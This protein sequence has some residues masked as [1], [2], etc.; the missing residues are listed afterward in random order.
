MK[1]YDERREGSSKFN[2][3]VESEGDKMILIEEEPS[4][5]LEMWQS[6]YDGLSQNQ[7]ATKTKTGVAGDDKNN[8]N[9]RKNCTVGHDDESST[10]PI[11]SNS[12]DGSNNNDQADRGEDN[13]DNDDSSANS[14]QNTDKAS[15][16]GRITLGDRIRQLRY[17]CGMVVN[18]PYVS[19][20]MILC[21][22]I[23]AI[24][25]GIA[26]YPFVKCNE[27][28][29]KSFAYTDQ[30]FLV[31]FTI[32]L[33]MQL[34]YLGHHLFYDM[35][36]VFDLVIITISLIAITDSS[37]IGGNFQIFRAFRIFRTLRLITRIRVM[38]DL[39]SGKYDTRK[40]ATT[41]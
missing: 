37:N 19:A 17:E 39:L 10:L 15:A 18:N 1:Q 36:L 38:R 6:Q 34:V 20:M 16:N 21:I 5:E 23:N 29:Q 31:I 26:T 30:V 4:G 11:G 41:I 28:V 25:M 12:N 8:K 9:G 7:I 32:E 35:W 14:S 27:D 2:S 40:Q 24:M 3:I 13:S 33:S 22:A